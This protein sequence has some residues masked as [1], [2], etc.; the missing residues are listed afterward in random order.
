MIFSEL[1][2]IVI[3]QLRIAHLNVTIMSTIN[4]R[5]PKKQDAYAI[6]QLIAQCPPLDLN[7]IYTYL[8]LAEHHAS[9]CVIAELDGGQLGGFISAY[10]HP[11]QTDTLFIWQVAVCVDAR[12]CGLGQRMIQHLLQRPRL[13]PIRYLET[14]V[15]PANMA[16]RRM[17]AR[18]ADSACAAV[19]ESALFD[20]SLFGPDG[21]EDERLIRIGPLSC[22][23]GM[24]IES[25]TPIV[26][27]LI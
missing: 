15:G 9:T 19:N 14:T 16:S 12:G 10:V 21:H 11:N 8:L 18:V 27:A 25:H 4:L 5:Q 13:E 7:S 6:H 17:F 2:S 23:A 3:D 26:H 1:I 20:R 24:V 22:A